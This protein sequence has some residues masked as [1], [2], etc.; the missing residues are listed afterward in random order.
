[1]D[2]PVSTKLNTN[3][4]NFNRIGSTSATP[5]PPQPIFTFSGSSGEH[6][7]HPPEVPEPPEIHPPLLPQKSGDSQPVT[8]PANTQWL[9]NKSGDPLAVSPKIAMPRRIGISNFR[10]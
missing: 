9:I 2:R 4:Y 6:S 5:Y 7:L 10:K 3:F 8:I 1:M